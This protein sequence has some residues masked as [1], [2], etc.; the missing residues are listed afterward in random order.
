[1][2]DVFKGFE[3]KVLLF[4]TQSCIRMMIPM[5]VRLVVISGVI[6]CWSGGFS[7]VSA[8]DHN[9][10]KDKLAEGSELFSEDTVV[11]KVGGQSYTLADLKK[12]YPATFYSDVE[13]KAFETISNMSQKL[14]LDEFYKNWAKKAKVSEDSA[15]S[16][17]LAK[18]VKVT[19]KQVKETLELHKD[20]PQ[21]KQMSD[22]DRKKAVHDSLVNQ[23]QRQA[24]MK[25]LADAIESK[26]LELVLAQPV[27]PQLDITYYDDDYVRYGPE[28]DDTKPLGCKADA[29]PITIVE[30]SEFQCP[31]C[32]R[33]PPVA[34]QVLAEY[35]GQIRW[36]VRDFPLDFHDRAVPAAIAAGCAYEQGKYWQMYA[37]LF[38]LQSDLSDAAIVKHAKSIGIYNTSFKN[39]IAK[40]DKIKARVDRNFDSGIKIGVSGTPGFYING[41]KSMI[42]M[43]F[44]GFKTAIDAELKQIKP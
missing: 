2:I 6:V 38:D 23:A 36:I 21:L 34:K 39:C 9:K 18:Q 29:C 41:K 5:I 32:A 33:V 3:W 15:R 26:K 28:L 14:Y 35:K 1:M 27:A 11:M 7:S 12:I 44:A 20:N 42:Q 10:T 16:D 30:Y 8:A 4:W 25:L 19:D 17:Y 22:A 37:K 31:Y 24:E 40:P 13:M 43:S